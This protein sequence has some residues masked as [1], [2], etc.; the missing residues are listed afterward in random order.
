MSGSEPT[1]AQKVTMA[2]EALA[3][4]RIPHAFGGALAL[5]YYGEPRLTIDIDLNVF[6][7]ADRFED[8]RL[9]LEPLGVD[10]SLD[11]AR[12]VEDGQVRI[13]WGRNPIDLFFSYDAFHDAMEKATRSVQFADG[14]IPILSPEH[15]IVCKAV[16]DRTKDWVDIEQVMLGED[17]MEEA[18]IFTWL[19]RILP[20]DDPRIQRVRDLWDLTRQ[21]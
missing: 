9:T 4:R 6:I 14:R 20:A 8:V 10:T 7:E 13:W 12:T 18:E 3:R 11:P 16:F 17:R 21:R 1:L 5:A 15:L 19:D 2:H